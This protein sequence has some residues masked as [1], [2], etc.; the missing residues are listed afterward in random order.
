MPSILRRIP[1][2]YLMLKGLFLFFLFAGTAGRA[3][4]TYIEDEKFGRVWTRL[5]KPAGFTRTDP[6][7][8]LQEYFIKFYAQNPA[9]PPDFKGLVMLTLIIDGEGF[10]NLAKAT[11]SNPEVSLEKLEIQKCIKEMPRWIPAVQNDRKVP[12]QV[13]LSL[14]FEGNK[15]LMRYLKY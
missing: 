15:V 12:F 8:N 2:L 10:A 5:D 9:I 13:L 1:Y 14:S 7:R 3:Q 11:G 4:S 6:E